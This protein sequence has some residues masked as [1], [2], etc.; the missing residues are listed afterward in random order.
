MLCLKIILII[1]RQYQI[2]SHKRDTV[3]AMTTESILSSGYL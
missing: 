1:F 3:T 2:I